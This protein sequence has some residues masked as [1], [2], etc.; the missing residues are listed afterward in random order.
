MSNYKPIAVEVVRSLIAVNISWSNLSTARTWPLANDAS[1]FGDRESDKA[2]IFYSRV[3]YNQDYIDIG[4]EAIPEIVGVDVVMRPTNRN[5]STVNLWKRD[6]ERLVQEIR[7]VV[8]QH[9]S[10]ASGYDMIR[11]TRVIPGD[12]TNDPMV[13]PPLL[14]TILYVTCLRYHEELT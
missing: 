1:T 5:P 10:N 2:Q 6:H 14:E 9:R 7:R 8:R 13:D 11:V 4:C 3:P 12:V